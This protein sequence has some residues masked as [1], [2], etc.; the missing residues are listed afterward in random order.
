MFFGGDALKMVWIYAWFYPAFM[1]YLVALWNRPVN[2]LPRGYVCASFTAIY[3]NLPIPV[4]VDE[5][6][7]DPARGL[8]AAILN[9]VA[10]AFHVWPVVPLDELMRLALDDALGKPVAGGYRGAA[11]AAAVTFAEWDF[12]TTS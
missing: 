2:R 9:L 5:K 4:A 7:P 11:V 8:I 6:L 3:P 10:V 12:H 1:V